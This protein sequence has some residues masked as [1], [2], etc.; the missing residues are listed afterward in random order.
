MARTFFLT[1]L[2]LLVAMPLGAA[3]RFFISRPVHAV[4]GSAVQ[5]SA[6]HPGAKPSVPVVTT[7]L[8]HTG[9]PHTDLSHTGLPL[10]PSRQA[11]AA[12]N[13]V[14]TGMAATPADQR[15]IPLLIPVE[16]VRLTELVDNFDQPRGNERHH[17]ALD[18]M[19][20]KGSKVI[21]AADG[22]V[23]KLFNSTAGG[24]TVYQFDPSEKYAY[25][26]AHLARYA[27]G[28]TEG[29]VLKRGDLLG[30]VGST[31][32]AEPNAPHLHFAVIE[33]TPA[34]QWWTGTALNP[35]PMLGG[36]VAAGR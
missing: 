3:S 16:G 24:L 13:A 28:L 27:H 23:V 29:S 21:A 19:A 18:I 34:R 35:Y 31:G 10:R 25:Y 20:P 5:T 36:S 8:P 32:N 4:P 22:T 33:L 1:L 6:V 14:G 30:Y 7:N 15:M 17:G 2:T 9:L 12:T 26:Y 11:G